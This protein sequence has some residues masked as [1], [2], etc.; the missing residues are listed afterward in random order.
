MKKVIKK[1]VVLFA[2]LLVFVIAFTVGCSNKASKRKDEY[3]NNF[4]EKE[5]YNTLDN[6]DKADNPEKDKQPLDDEK[7]DDSNEIHVH[8]GGDWII[9]KE[10][11]KTEDGERH[12][13]CTVCGTVESE[14]IYAI[15]SQGLAY[16]L[17]YDETECKITGIGTCTDTEIY[18]PA[19]IDGHKVTSID[20]SFS[21]NDSITKVIIANGI[22]SIEGYAFQNCE[23]L[24]TVVIPESV[25]NIGN[26]AFYGCKKLENIAIS[27][28]VISI[29]LRAFAYCESLES[30]EV[31]LENTEYKSIDGNLYT[32][33]GNVL[34]QYAIGKKDKSFV[35]PD[36]VKTI[37][38]LAFFCSE[39]LTS[40]TV[41]VGVTEIDDYSFAYC[42]EL[43]DISLPEGIETI[44]INAFYRCKR[45]KAASLP[46]SLS[47]IGEEAFEGCEELL[48]VVIPSG[49]EN[50]E[51]RTFASCFKLKNVTI[52][53][54]VIYIGENAF[55]SCDISILKLPSTVNFIDAQ[56]FCYCDLLDIQVSENNN[57]YKAVNGDLYAKDGT[58]L[59]LAKPASTINICSGTT[60]IGAYS[61]TNS[62]AD[63]ITIPAS[64]TT[65][66]TK[67]F[68]A[69]FGL[70]EITYLGTQEQWEKI[71]K[72]GDCFQG[73]TVKVKCID[74]YINITN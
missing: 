49:V 53:E 3:I 4:E 48:S 71:V 67:A 1:T 17:S 60:I 9:D 13:E 12:R 50:I 58:S 19:Y 27:K 73:T 11:T 22:G 65:I 38:E 68:Y 57:S 20:Y 40:I 36:G 66:E 34:I 10:A 2:F 32:K 61:C 24:K 41:P 70:K 35:V 7:D 43:S 46:S 21:Y 69:L 31:D 6:D 15:G 42:Q 54:G 45:L 51:E 47:K 5:D 63:T 25:T 28:N 64:V 74:G 59:I 62:D 16:Y 52:S 23:S 56:A 39:Q 26:E 55:F 72:A 37:G 8:T 33:D 18:I 44:G 29:G 30:I 14:I